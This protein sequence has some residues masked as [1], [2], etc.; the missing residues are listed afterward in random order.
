MSDN[1]QRYLVGVVAELQVLQFESEGVAM[2]VFELCNGRIY[3][4]GFEREG[5]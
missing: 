2:Q 3:V 4:G 5:V 1:L